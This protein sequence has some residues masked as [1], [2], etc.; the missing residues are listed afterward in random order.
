MTVTST[1]SH[2]K[3]SVMVTV[4]VRRLLRRWLPSWVW[5]SRTRYRKRLETQHADEAAL[6]EAF[7]LA[8]RAYSHSRSFV[9]AHIGGWLTGA[10]YAR[11]KALCD[12]CPA[13]RKAE[14]GIIRCHTGKPCACPKSRWWL[15]RR[16]GWQARLATWPCPLGKF[17]VEPP[18]PWYWA[19]PII[20]AVVVLYLA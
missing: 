11:R 9:L 4:V 14:D 13:K 16:I 20:I 5:R 6:G 1:V 3:H 12:G 10:R 2:R 17:A 15:P 19:I 8:F 18:E 7:E